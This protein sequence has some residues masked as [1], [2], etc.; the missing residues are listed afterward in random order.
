MSY[1]TRFW[2]KVEKTETCWLWTAAKRPNGYGAHGIQGR[3]TSTHRIAWEIAFGPIPDGMCVLHWCD[4]RHC[5]RPDHLFLGTNAENQ[6][7]MRAKGR[8]RKA[9]GAAAGKT[10]LTAAQ[11]ADIR[12]R[13]RYWGMR[14]AVGRE[15]GVHESTIAAILARKSW[16]HLPAGAAA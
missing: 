1:V 12:L 4:V 14:A 16:K 10:R 3:C 15:F 13:P 6:A 8:S 7:D 11:V 9:V 2:E 5:V